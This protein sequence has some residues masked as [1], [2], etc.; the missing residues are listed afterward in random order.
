MGGRK[1]LQNN[2]EKFVKNLKKMFDMLTG[3]KYYAVITMFIHH[4][5]IKN[6]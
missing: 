2:Y 3:L 1:F 4:C 5:K 6:V